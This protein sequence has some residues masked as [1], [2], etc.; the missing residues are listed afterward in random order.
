MK[1]KVIYQQELTKI[2]KKNETLNEENKIQ[3]DESK[4]GEKAKI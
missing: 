2:K 1:K 3:K 4:R